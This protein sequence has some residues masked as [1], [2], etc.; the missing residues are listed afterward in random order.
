MMRPIKFRGKRVDN[1]EWVY[2][3]L[4]SRS[5]WHPRALP[6]KRYI[7]DIDTDFPG[8]PENEDDFHEVIPKTVGQF[9]ERKDPNG[10]EIFDGDVFHGK[11][12]NC[13]VY[14]NKKYFGWYI[15]NKTECKD[16]LVSQVVDYHLLQ[17]IGNIHE[18]P[19]LLEG[20]DDG[21][22]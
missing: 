4:V 13:T 1:G 2:G 19:E 17:V 10:V 8:D 3:D 16:L 21:K 20:G 22:N 7:L 5:P 12:D 6:D 15:K 18:N 14:W 9:T 11:R